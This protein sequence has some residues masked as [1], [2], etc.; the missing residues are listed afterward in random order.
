MDYQKIA[1]GV[2]RRIVGAFLSFQ[3]EP[4]DSRAS[5]K[6]PAVQYSFPNK[7]WRQLNVLKKCSGN[8]FT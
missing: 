5:A 1:A 7:P 2:E 8:F 6:N 4:A 3:A